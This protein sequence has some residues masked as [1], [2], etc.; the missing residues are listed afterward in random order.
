MPTTNYF[1]RRLKPTAQV[2]II[3]TA[4]V[5]SESMSAG[6]GHTTNI[7]IGV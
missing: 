3:P 2:R 5:I 6:G 4:E 1:C 7:E